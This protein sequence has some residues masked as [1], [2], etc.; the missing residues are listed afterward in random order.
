VRTE[1]LRRE[2]NLELRLTCFPLHPDTPEHG[3]TLEQLFAGRLDIP[4]ALTRLKQVAD[5]L[6]LPLADRT[7]TYNSR[8][9]QELGKWAEEQGAGEAFH[10]AAYFAYFAEGKNIARVD[11]LQGIAEKVGLS[12]QDAVNVLK[13]KSFADAVDADWQRAY[14]LGVNAVPTVIYGQRKLVGFAGEEDYRRLI[15]E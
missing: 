12:V 7:H 13:Q 2:F 14:S 4:N 1:Q 6:D 10:A 15:L 9:A 11:V 5:S 8:G 3:Q